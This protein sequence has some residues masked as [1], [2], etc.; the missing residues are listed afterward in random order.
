VKVRVSNPDGRFEDHIGAVGIDGLS[1][2]S[3]S[4]AVMKCATKASRR[5]TIAFCG[6]G[7]LDETEVSS[8]PDVVVNN[9]N[10]T[11]PPPTI[12]KP[13]MLDS[14]PLPTAAPPAKI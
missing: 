7:M 8:I 11:T 10:P 5:G 14:R 3:L 9:P 2:E 12:V 13:K 4:N 1:G 6:L